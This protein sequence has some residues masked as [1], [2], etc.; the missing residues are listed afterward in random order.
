MVIPLFVGRE[1]SIKAL[2]AAMREDKQIILVAQ[3]SAETDEPA[4]AD[5]YT[6]GTLANI[7]QLL[8]LPD[9]TVK[10]LVEGGSRSKLSDISEAE[11]YFSA[12]FSRVEDVS[13]DDDRELEVLMRSAIA[14]FDQYVKLNKKIP[15]KCSPHFPVLSP[16]VAWRIPW[17]RTCR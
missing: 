17:L 6:V 16:P 14:L 10:V 4:V 13:P 5:M 11:G 15:P 2:D 12:E 7:L 9:G 1:K 3:K 8:K